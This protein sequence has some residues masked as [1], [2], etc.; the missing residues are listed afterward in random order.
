MERTTNTILTN[1]CMICDGDK[2]LVQ[3]KVNSSYTGVTFPGGHIENGESLT[4]G[5]IREVLEETGLCI[6]NP[7]LC[8]IYNWIFD[9]RTRYIVFLYKTTRFTGVLQSSK[10]GAVR[11]I[12]KEEFLNEKLAFGMDKVFQIIH[13]G[14]FTE[15]YYDWIEKEEY[16]QG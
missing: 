8:G 13:H 4:E 11:W 14:Q 10:E 2:I 1:M 5:M 15:C 12:K 6:E 7:R 9:D 16:L 3:D